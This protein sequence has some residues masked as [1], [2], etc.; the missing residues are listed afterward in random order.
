MGTQSPEDLKEIPPTAFLGFGIS[1]LVALIEFSF[2]VCHSTEHFFG[3]CSRRK[4]STNRENYFEISWKHQDLA[5]GPTASN[6]KGLINSV[7]CGIQ[8]IVETVCSLL[9]EE[10]LLC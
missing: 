10:A 5:L 9:V 1:G 2:T 3:L 7:H 4:L 6:V 8:C